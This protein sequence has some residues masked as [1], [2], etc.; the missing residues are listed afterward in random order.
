MHLYC[1]KVTS[2]S[3]FLW[4]ETF[5]NNVERRAVS[6]PQLSFLSLFVTDAN[7]EDAFQVNSKCYKVHKTEQVDWFTAVNRCRSN[8][9]SLA[10]FDDHVRQYFPS[11]LLLD[12]VTAWIGLMKSWWTWPG[13]LSLSSYLFNII[14][15]LTQ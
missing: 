5:L 7:C 9:A 2:L 14:T 4:I 15:T 11:S 8:N 3:G 12:D 1:D 10:V 6:L 13:Y